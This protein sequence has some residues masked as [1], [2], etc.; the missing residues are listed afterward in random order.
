MGGVR[1]DTGEAMRNRYHIPAQQVR[2]HIDGTFFTPLECFPG[3][4]ADPG[5]YVLFATEKQYME[6]PRLDHRGSVK[7]PRLGVS[8]SVSKHPGY[9]QF[10]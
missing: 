7:N 4:L 1:T 5:G 3:A 2:Y 6:D 10:K 8:G 9:R